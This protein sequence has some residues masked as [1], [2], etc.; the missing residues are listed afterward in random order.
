MATVACNSTAPA[1]ASA[2]GSTAPTAAATTHW[3]Q[4]A[5]KRQLHTAC[6]HN[7]IACSA[8]VAATSLQCATTCPR[9]AAQPPLTLLHR[10]APPTA[11]ATVTQHTWVLGSQE[12]PAMPLLQWLLC[13][14]HVMVA[15]LHCWD[16]S[17]PAQHPAVG[18]RVRQTSEQPQRKTGINSS[19]PDRPAL[20][21]AHRQPRTTLP[22]HWC[23]TQ[24]RRRRRQSNELVIQ[25]YSSCHPHTHTSH[26]LPHTLAAAGEGPA[27]PTH[28]WHTPLTRPS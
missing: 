13:H 7:G 8:P 15:V 5:S 16:T 28:A 2:A 25:G 24:C 10:H 3:K 17:P 14:T 19:H 4:G 6:R 18:L 1:A 23:H 22:N 20:Q 12:P 26:T 9:V 21:A 11:R 27:H